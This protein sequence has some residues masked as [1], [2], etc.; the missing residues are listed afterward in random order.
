MIWAEKS[1]GKEVFLVYIITFHVKLGTNPTADCVKISPDLIT[2][3]VACEL[4]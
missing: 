3:P 1:N 4:N 2:S